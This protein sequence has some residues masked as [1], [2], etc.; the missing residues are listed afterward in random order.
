MNTLP[1]DARFTG[2]GGHQVDDVVVIA[3]HPFVWVPESHPCR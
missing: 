2:M 3:E 1:A